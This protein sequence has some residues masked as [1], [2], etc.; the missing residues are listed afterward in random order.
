V[1][2]QLELFLDYK[3]ENSALLSLIKFDCRGFTYFMLG[4]YTVF[5]DNV[6]YRMQYLIAAEKEYISSEAQTK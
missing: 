5:T 2:H 4:I 3:T 6:L 1:Q